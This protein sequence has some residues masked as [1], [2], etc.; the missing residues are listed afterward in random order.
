MAQVH[1]L[2]LID[3]LRPHLGGAEKT[4][5]RMAELLPPDRFRCSV[6]TFKVPGEYGT[7]QEVAAVVPCPFHYFPIGRI[8]S[9]QCWS[10]LAQLR[11]LIRR[12][13][14]S[15]THTFFP[16][17][18]L[19]GG[20]VAK[21]SGCPVVISSRR[22]MGITR[23]CGHSLL[24]RGMVHV[25]DEVHAV[26]EQVKHWTISQDGLAADR[27]FTL[28]NGIDMSRLDAIS[29][30]S[31]AEPLLSNGGR[32]VLTVANARPVKGLDVFLRMATLIHREEPDVT[33]V[34]VGVVDG[35]YGDQ[36]RSLTACM[37]EGRVLF[38]GKISNAASLIRQADVF[39][40]L[41]RSEGFSNALIEAMACR[42]PCVATAV[43]GNPEALEDGRNGFL[44]D[45]DDPEAAADRVLRL[46]RHED[47]RKSF[48]TAARNTIEARFTEDRLIRTLIQRYDAL[49]SPKQSKV[50]EC[51]RKF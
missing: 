36:L 39:C 32:I 21:A 44:V 51:M 33:F 37:P 16:T 45:S 30:G 43:G 17:S 7:P 4:M 28:Y 19:I 40:L 11:R 13:R 5:L 20:T 2:F 1:V 42:V 31:S 25:V 47:L 49:L 27:I 14:V 46:L 10:A 38:V 3:E 24:Y 15:I 29:N 35:P 50:T 34:V 26:S 12:E 6:A 18:D 41:S 22:D 23:R 48:G 9:P 8:G